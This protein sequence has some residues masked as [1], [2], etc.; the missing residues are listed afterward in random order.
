MLDHLF[1]GQHTQ[2][3]D[4]GGPCIHHTILGAFFFS[5]FFGGAYRN[6]RSS[7]VEQRKCVDAFECEIILVNMGRYRTGHEC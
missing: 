7:V 5:Q 1:V 3:S 2:V 6:D 4:W